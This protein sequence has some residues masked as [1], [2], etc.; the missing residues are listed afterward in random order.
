MQKIN[1]QQFKIKNSNYREAFEDLCYHLFCREF[2]IS[3]KK[4]IFGYFAQRGLET[5]PVLVNRKWHGFQAKFFDKRLSE[6]KQDIIESIKEAKDNYRNNLNIIYFYLNKSFSQGKNGGK[7]D[8]QKEIEVAAKKNKI[9]IEWIVP[10]R[11]E[12]LLNNPS[13]LDLAQL[14]FGHGDELGFIRSNCDP[15]IITFLQSSEYL[16]LP[17]KG[18]TE[19]IKKEMLTNSGKEFLIL[20]H[21]GSGKTIYMNKLLV[22]FGGLDQEDMKRMK[23]IIDKNHAIPML[24]SLRDCVLDSL[25]NIIRN[26]QKDYEVR[27]KEI[28][29]IYIFDGLDELISERA[30]HILSYISLLAKDERTKKI[31]VSCRSGNHN[32]YLF[33]TYFPDAKEYEID[34]L[35]LGYID[36]YFSAK[37]D[38]KKLNILRNLKKEN[39]QLLK[40]IKDIFLINLLWS[41]IEKINKESSTIDL[42]QK[43]IDLLLEDPKFKK[44]IQELNLLD[45]KAEA[46]ISLNQD[47]SFEFQRHFQHRLTQ[48]EIQNL[49]LKRFPRLNYKDVNEVLTYLC[50]QFFDSEKVNRLKV[51]SYIYQHRRYQEL[52]FAQKLKS[53]YEKDRRILRD[54]NVLSNREFFEELFLPYLRQEYEK[55]SN[56][57]KL[58]ELNLIDVYLGKH[59][60]YGV[61]EPYFMNSSGFIPSLALQNDAV[62]EQLLFDD[63]LR[64]KEKILG[65][66]EAIASFWRE[67]KQNLAKQLLDNFEKS[68]EQA[69]KERNKEKLK[70]INDRIWSQ[71]K[72]W[73]YIRI[74]IKQ[75]SISKIFKHLIRDNYHRFSSED[76]YSVEESGKERLVKSFFRVCLD[77][78][79]KELLKL[80]DS[81]DEYEFLAFLDVLREVEYIPGLVATNIFHSKIKSFLEVYKKK[82]T[83]ENFFLLFYKKFFNMPLTKE[84]QAFAKEQLSKISKRGGPFDLRRNYYKYALISYA[85]D[86]R[87]FDQMPAMNFYRDLFLYAALFYE[88]IEMLKGN[89]SVA[90]IV[91]NYILYINNHE[92]IT[93]HKLEA[94]I[95]LLWSYVFAY[96]ASKDLVALKNRL[97]RRENDIIPFSVLRIL[98]F[99]NKQR[100]NEL[101][102]EQQIEELTRMHD[103]WKDDFNSYVDR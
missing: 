69:K 45:S 44:N 58:I 15:T 67:G 103:G 53:E 84:E 79:K 42:F 17:F 65:K 72:N 86:E 71:W 26:R 56:L 25:E 77:E 28:G 70:S 27:S 43:R 78:K 11:F 35:G 92:K 37:N 62:L 55:E 23:Q 76:K 7:P 12:I 97:V 2:K 51:H 63:N 89:R 21:P 46:I 83:E 95:S 34:Q 49:I 98:R 48:E 33:K 80:V 85:V 22:D 101:T 59:K 88:F 91:R 9:T 3:R 60:G 5:E 54:L 19:D 39:N 94:D 41:A 24:V 30:D 31:I 1:F 29:F 38:E 64:I 6:S 4:G 20:G 13:N 52:F 32:K 96:C 73:L 50:S 93:T 74:V 90:S 57:P 75:K 87:T 8:Y 81:F 61:D 100:I 14:Y 18:A 82:I 36:R 10:S 47:I 16:K 68:I 66:L 99:N 102:K 40:D